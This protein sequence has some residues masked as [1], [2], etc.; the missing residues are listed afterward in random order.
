[1]TAGQNNSFSAKPKHMAGKR[2]RCFSTVATAR[3]KVY[4][5]IKSRKH[6]LTNH[7]VGKSVCFFSANT[8]K[9]NYKLNQFNEAHI[10]QTQGK[11]E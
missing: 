1:M 3:K 10:I 8:A 7:K 2:R 11:Q 6:I 4:S 5:L 9:K